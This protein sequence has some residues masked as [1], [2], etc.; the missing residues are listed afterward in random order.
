MF[1]I[2]TKKIIDNIH[3]ICSERPSKRNSRARNGNT[4][5]GKRAENSISA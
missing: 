1:K 3:L 4:A 5:E 2:G